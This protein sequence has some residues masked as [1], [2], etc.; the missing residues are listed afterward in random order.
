[1]TVI[2]TNLKALVAQQSLVKNERSLQDAMA[3]L[4]TGR[5]INSAKDD[6]AGLAIAN[7]LNMQVRGLAQAMRNAGDGI[8]MLQTADGAAEEITNM[9]VRMRELAVQSVNGTNGSSERVALDSEFGEL[10]S[11]IAQI[12]DNTQ[13]NGMNILDGS[14]TAVSFQV[15]AGSGQTVSFT[16]KDLDASAVGVH[17]TS[18]TDI[19]SAGAAT[20]AISAIDLA[21]EAVDS[22]R[23]EAGAKINR[24]IHAADNSANVMTHTA[25]SRSRVL[26]A[27]YAKATSEL[28]RAQII[29]QA[30]T[31]MLSQANQLPRYVM[32]L[33]G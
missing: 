21:I 19:L 23:G 3:Q 11:Q 25:A 17:I 10:Q 28:A 29:Q 16:F 26:D 18:G 4:S 2:N 8:S 9:L 33:L 12:T 7:R 22:F 30:G 31:A 24:L 13:W 14:T 6:A 32:A 1:M 20:A 15:G 5:R 27:D